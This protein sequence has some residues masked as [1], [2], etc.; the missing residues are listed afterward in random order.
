M[1]TIVLVRAD[2]VSGT[3]GDLVLQARLEAAGHTVVRVA[4]EDPEYGG[5][6]DGVMISD[7]CSGG[8]VGAK[9]DTVAKPGITC[10][11]VTWR[12]GTYLG[13]ITGTN[14]T[15]QN[16]AGNAG[17]TGDQVIYSE[18]VSQQG[19]D[20]DVLPAAATVVARLTGDADHG[21][22]V[23]YEAGGA[24]TSGT[25]PAR[26]VFLRIG[27]PAVPVLTAAG[28]ALV[29]AAIT[30]AFGSASTSG[31]L[32]AT[33]PMPTAAVAGSVRVTGAVA[34]SAPL[35]TATATGTVRAA[36]SL[37]GS[38][39]MPTAAVAGSVRVTGQVAGSVPMPSASLAGTVRATGSLTTVLPLPGASLASGSGAAGTLAG[40][41]PMPSGEFAAGVAA[42]GTL[43]AFLAL[44]VAALSGTAQ[45][46][47][48]S[49]RLWA[50]P[51]IRVREAAA[52]TPVRG[53][54]IAGQP[55][56][57]QLAAAG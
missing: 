37:A 6:Y 7:S 40:L 49:P 26:R 35:P 44:P 50:G 19:V 11:N 57:R 23:T 39:P 5:A 43:A 47:N 1:G 28:L 38:A 30:W 12:L 56:R 20:T 22:Y 21:T 14:W 31:A 15:V 34:C 52:G 29:D 33:V 27:D 36:A 17:L 13:G 53:G 41:L 18:A 54:L 42:T 25:A 24:L 3:A 45:E 32:A 16:V 2:A 51:P 48:Q 4:D 9:Y 55:V 46:P 10:E 8:T